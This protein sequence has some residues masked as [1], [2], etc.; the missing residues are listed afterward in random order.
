MKHKK[1]TYSLKKYLRRKK[2]EI[3][4]VEKNPEKQAEKIRELAAKLNLPRY[5]L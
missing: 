4:R 5:G 3:R 1:I 2:A